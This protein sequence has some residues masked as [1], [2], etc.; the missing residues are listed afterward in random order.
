MTCVRIVSVGP[1]LAPDQKASGP[2]IC[3][4]RGAIVVIANI[5][6]CEALSLVLSKAETVDRPWYTGRRAPR[7]AGPG[8][9]WMLRVVSKAWTSVLGCLACGLDRLS[10][11]WIL[12][13]IRRDCHSQLGRF[14]R[15][16]ISRRKDGPQADSQAAGRERMADDRRVWLNSSCAKSLAVILGAVLCVVCRVLCVVCCVLC[17]V[18]RVASWSGCLQGVR[19]LHCTV[20]MLRV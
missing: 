20:L 1:V 4:Q 17:V 11:D 3:S 19:V 12:L 6:A 16:S 9:R 14:K 7:Q 10:V 2:L 5:C 13:C 15:A 8:R 18:C